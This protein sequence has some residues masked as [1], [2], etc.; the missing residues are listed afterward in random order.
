MAISAFGI[1]AS[2]KVQVFID[3]KSLNNQYAPV[4]ENDTTL[5]PMRDIFYAFGAGIESKKAVTAFNGSIL[6]VSM[7]FRL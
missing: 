1:S 3:G 6:P 5:I 2:A 4:I 7:Y